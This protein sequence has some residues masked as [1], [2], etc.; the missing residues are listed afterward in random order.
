MPEQII[1]TL[2]ISGLAGVPGTFFGF[3]LRERADGMISLP[4]KEFYETLSYMGKKFSR[5]CWRGGD[6]TSKI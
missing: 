3:K 2:V 1:H 6:C 5:K 4:V